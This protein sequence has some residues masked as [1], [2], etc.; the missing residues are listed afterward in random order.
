MPRITEIRKQRAARKH[1]IAAPPPPHQPP[2]YQQPHQ[3]HEKFRESDFTKKYTPSHQQPQHLRGHPPAPRKKSVKFRPTF[4]KNMLHMSQNLEDQLIAP[5]PYNSIELFD[6]LNKP[7]SSSRVDPL[8]KIDPRT[9]NR[10]NFVKLPKN[11]PMPTTQRTHYTENQIESSNTFPLLVKSTG[12]KLYLGEQPN[13]S[14]IIPEEISSSWDNHISLPLPN[15]P[16]PEGVLEFI[17]DMINVKKNASSDSLFPLNPEFLTQEEENQRKNSSNSNENITIHNAMIP[18]NDTLVPPLPPFQPSLVPQVVV[19]EVPQ[20]PQEPVIQDNE[21]I[22]ST[23]II[24]YNRHSDKS[25][26]PSTFHNSEN[27]SNDQNSEQLLNDTL[28]PPPPTTTTPEILENDKSRKNNNII[29]STPNISLEIVSHQEDEEPKN[30]VEFLA[31]S[32]LSRKD[33]LPTHSTP[34]ILYPKKPNSTTTT[35]PPPKTQNVQKSQIQKF[36][37]NEI[38]DEK[39]HPYKGSIFPLNPGFFSNENN[40]NNNLAGISK[41]IVQISGSSSALPESDEKYSIINKGSLH[42]K[43][44]SI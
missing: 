43:Q 28:V 15:P 2:P 30:Q 19:P 20:V 11:H 34:I 14:S 25:I 6:Y 38:I 12:P 17:G 35:P 4:R 31:P 22:H 16:A 33:F 1:S 10:K 40:N 42:P 3:F 13:G 26:L 18:V 23:P 29:H 32:L 7:P 41:S 36:N 39:H 9:N 24:F 44:L 8:L 21:I 37:S 5:K 27:Q